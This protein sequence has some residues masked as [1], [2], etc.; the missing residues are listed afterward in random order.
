MA[1]DAERA[2]LPSTAEPKSE[3]FLREA[4]DPQTGELL[5][6]RRGRIWEA[7][8]TAHATG[9]R[10]AGKVIAV[11]DIG[12]DATRLPAERLHPASVVPEWVP[13]PDRGRHGT[14]V[15]LLV[16]AAAPEAQLLAT[17]VREGDRFSVLKTAAAITTAAQHGATVVNVSAEFETDCALRMPT[18]LG[19]EV[20][21]EVD[22]DPEKFVAAVERWLDYAEPYADARCRRKCRICDA[23]IAVSG[24]T[25]TIAASGNRYPTSCPACTQ[26]SVGVGFQRSVL[27]ERNG[28]VTLER[29]LPRTEHGDYTNPELMLD[30]PVGFDGTSFASPLLAGLTALLDDPLDT[31]RMAG[32]ARAATPLLMLALAYRD[33]FENATPRTVDTLLRGFSLFAARIPASH[34][35]WLE[36]QPAPCAICALVLTDWYDTLTSVHLLRRATDDALRWGMTVATLAPFSA[37]SASNAGLALAQHADR[38]AADQRAD[39]L[40]HAEAYL[41]RAVAL[42]PE[43]GEYRRQLELVSGAR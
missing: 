18:G 29:Q 34:H 5:A 11:V 37:T 8:A 6:P 42:A 16:A 20:L 23:V 39:A 33:E 43:I 10:G 30:E 19:S 3:V 26:G 38:S 41:E 2:G 32:L 31:R 22:P 4:F 40:A 28:G 14:A 12:F 17:D 27:V 9:S 25:V 21:F 1:P 15:A 13:H 24:T 36:P 7:I 35:H